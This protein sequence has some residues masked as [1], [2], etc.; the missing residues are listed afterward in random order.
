MARSLGSGPGGG[1]P[2]FCGSRLT[3]K[4]LVAVVT[5]EIKISSCTSRSA[6]VLPVSRSRRSREA[7]AGKRWD[8]LPAQPSP[9]A[10]LHE[11]LAPPA[12]PPPQRLSGDIELLNQTASTL[13]AQP[14]MQ[15]RDQDHDHP[16]V[17]LQTS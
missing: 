4:E 10:R 9:A 14:M 17:D 8:E 1:D 15:G 5:G 13:R 3:G 11:L 6:S 16:Q 2:I 12:A 7:V